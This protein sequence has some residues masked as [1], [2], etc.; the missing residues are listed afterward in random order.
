MKNV[1][2]V[3]LLYIA[4][5]NISKIIKNF[6]IEKN[7]KSALK[8]AYCSLSKQN[9]IISAAL[10]LVAGDLKSAVQITYEKLE[11]PILAF[12]IIML[13]EK[14]VIGLMINLFLSTVQR[15]DKVIPIFIANFVKKEDVP[16]MIELLLLDEQNS[17]NP[18]LMGDKR[19]AL[20]QIYH[21][22]TNDIKLLPIIANN[23]INDELVSLVNY[24]YKLPITHQLAQ[25][26]IST[27]FLA[28][29]NSQENSEEEKTEK[30]EEND[31]KGR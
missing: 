3:T 10:F 16:A 2:S 27:E 21:R 31:Y 17:S 25:S 1:D 12:L 6:E 23:T 14:S 24:I 8:N 19:I 13:V 11:D 15:N 29:N 30:N 22:L 5:S 26:V 7:R 4:M 28:T 9:F 18:S 20:Y